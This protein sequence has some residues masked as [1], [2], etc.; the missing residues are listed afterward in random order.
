VQ[1]LNKN[2]Q[3]MDAGL[4]YNQGMVVGRYHSKALLP[5]MLGVRRKVR[6][7]DGYAYVRSDDIFKSLGWQETEIK[8]LVRYISYE[9]ALVHAQVLNLSG[10][11][12]EKTTFEPFFKILCRLD[13]TIGIEN[14]G[15]K[16]ADTIRV[17]DILSGNSFDVRFDGINAPE[18]S[19]VTSAYYNQQPS[20]VEIIDKSSPGFK[21]SQ[22]TI[23]ALKGRV[24]LLRVKK[25]RETGGL[26]S[27]SDIENFEPGAG[28]NKET[29]YLK[30]IYG[31]TLA[32]IFYNVSEEKLISLKDF[33]YNLFVLY[34]FDKSKIKKA[35]KDSFYENSVIYTKY[36]V[37]FNNINSSSE[38]FKDSIVGAPVVDH[39]TNYIVGNNEITNPELR[40]LF[41][42]M[43]EMKIL[44]QIYKS[45]SRWP[46]VLWDEYYDDGTPYTLNWELVINNLATVFTNDLLT[47]S[48]SVNKAIDSV[49]ITTKVK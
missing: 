21:S 38:R 29:N 14:T 43:V 25:S 26:A 27:E 49:G 23:N 7:A 33:V 24:F 4:S 37:I 22:F 16:D 47:E 20:E 31:R 36:S 32:T 28:F 42:V 6:T 35:F 3:P 12:P 40:R 41:S 2:G 19:V 46:M 11:G 10:L 34:N 30:E 45:A 17:V 44:E 15:V 9:N 39:I 48:D 18:K 8:E 13:T 1:Y 5:G